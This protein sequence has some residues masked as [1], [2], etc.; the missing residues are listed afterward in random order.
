MFVVSIVIA[1][2]SAL[3]YKNTGNIGWL[4]GCAIWFCVAYQYYQKS[5]ANKKFEEDYKAMM[6]DIKI[7]NKEIELKDV[8]E[9]EKEV[10]EGNTISL[11]DLKKELK[12]KDDKPI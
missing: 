3:N 11:E 2:I 12:E 4:F 7:L 5:I 8:E 1:L 9:G 10:A 6:E